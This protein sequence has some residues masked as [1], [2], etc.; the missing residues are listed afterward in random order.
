MK[1]KIFCPVCRLSFLNSEAL[2]DGDALICPICGAKLQVVTL[3]PEVQV[4]KYPQDPKDEINERLNTFAHL[5][6]FVFNED[7]DDILTGMMQKKEKYG[8]FYCPCKL[9]N[10]PENICPCLET[11]MGQVIKKGH[12]H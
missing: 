5:R 12:C 10:I 7:R 3:S 4:T 8:D 1:N 9:D 6:N 2:N 11:R